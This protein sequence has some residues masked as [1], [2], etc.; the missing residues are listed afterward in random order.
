MI[1]RHNLWD[2]PK[3]K[4]ENGESYAA[5]AIREVQEE[6]GITELQ[7][8]TALPSTFHTYVLNEKPVL[9]ETHWFAMTSACTRLIPQTA[10]DI[11]RAK[12]IP[13]EQVDNLLQHSYLSL[14]DLWHNVW[15]HYA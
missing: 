10:E 14:L 11:T 13:L 6:T 4:V 12:W 2:F 15:Q 9:K 3:G 7:L 5:A 8:R 1:C